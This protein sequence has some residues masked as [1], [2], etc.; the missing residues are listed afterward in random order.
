[1]AN[2]RPPGVR[3]ATGDAAGTGARAPGAQNA[4][5]ATRPGAAPRPDPRTRQ[6]AR[7]TQ[8]NPPWTSANATGVRTIWGA[9]RPRTAGRLAARGRGADPGGGER[10]ACRS[11]VQA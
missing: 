7:R 5:D 3:A 1:A 2:C 4:T 6:P 10:G 9:G 8:D 11:R